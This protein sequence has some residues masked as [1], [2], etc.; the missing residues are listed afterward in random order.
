MKRLE[1]LKCLNCGSPLHWGDSEIVKCPYCRSEYI[2]DEGITLY[3]EPTHPNVDVYDM[4]L[5]QSKIKLNIYGRVYEFYISEFEVE[6]QPELETTCLCDFEYRT[7]VSRVVPNV[8]MR[9]I[10]IQE[11][12]GSDKE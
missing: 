10:G 8:N 3:E 4:D 7:V 1:L 11:L 9:L 5:N 12:K 2:K 6:Y